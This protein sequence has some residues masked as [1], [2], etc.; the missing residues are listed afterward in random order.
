MDGAPVFGA[1]KVTRSM[2]PGIAVTA[3]V[4]GT[5]PVK[6]T[7][8]GRRLDLAAVVF[9]PALLMISATI[10]EKLPVKLPFPPYV[11]VML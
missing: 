11:A 8:E 6:I 9:D 1:F 3:A 7:T 2:V 4:A 5:A 10:G